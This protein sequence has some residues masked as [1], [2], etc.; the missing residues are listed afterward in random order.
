MEMNHGARL[1]VTLLINIAMRAVQ[2]AIDW[3][4]VPARQAVDPPDVDRLVSLSFDRRTRKSPI[5]P[6]NNGRRQI[7]MEWLAE[8]RHNDWD[9]GR[10]TRPYRSRDGERIDE[11]F[12]T[13]SLIADI[14]MRS[15]EIP[16]AGG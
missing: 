5:I 11:L 10:I 9:F 12:E 7:A 8:L 2:T 14:C 15:Q 6:P 3:K 13:P 4:M 16:A 1:G